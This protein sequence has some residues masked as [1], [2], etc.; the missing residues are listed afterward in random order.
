MIRTIALIALVGSASAA[1]A[2]YKTAEVGCAN[3]Y[4]AVTCDYYLTEATCN[5][6]KSCLFVAGAGEGDNGHCGLS[7]DEEVT[8]DDDSSAADTAL[9]STIDACEAKDNT[10][11]ACTGDCAPGREICEPSAAKI[12]TVLTAD[13]ANAGILG[14]SVAEAVSQATC[15][16]YETEAACTAVAACEFQTLVVDGE[17][18]GSR[19][20]TTK[21]VKV[22]SIKVLCVD[23]GAT[24]YATAAAAA[25][26][27]GADVAAP[28]MV[29]L[30][31][32]V[33]ALAIF[34]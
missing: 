12:T 14:Y 8:W 2:D 32:L 22:E 28:L 34:A 10:A 20:G 19:C 4:N 23:N 7:A 30:S 9:Q 25:T 18:M 33:A 16:S 29:V 5:A 1:A 3:A 21:L 15:G 24:S 26:P 27:S 13:D 11:A 17:T 6:D 31:T